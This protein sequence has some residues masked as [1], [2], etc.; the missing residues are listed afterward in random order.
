MAPWAHIR[1]LPRELRFEIYKASERQRAKDAQDL[2]TRTLG[3]LS[4]EFCRG[5]VTASVL[6]RRGS[7]VYRIDYD[8]NFVWGDAAT[9]YVVFDTVDKR[10]LKYKT[11][12]WVDAN[13]PATSMLTKVPR[14]VDFVSVMFDS[15]GKPRVTC[16]TQLRLTSFQEPEFREEVDRC[17]NRLH[18]MSL[19]EL[20][21]R[22]GKVVARLLSENRFR[23]DRNTDAYMLLGR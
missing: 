10:V 1:A 6:M 23:F 4:E 16:A 8:T 5:H 3:T 9:A 11:E 7:L 19:R 13:R 22:T 14:P 12:C 2:A 20:E 18:H 15:S 21:A 17:M